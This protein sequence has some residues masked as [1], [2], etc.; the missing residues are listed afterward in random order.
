MMKKIETFIDKVKN[1][2]NI[3]ISGHKNPDGDAMGCALALMKV[4]E[5]N[6]NKKATVIYDGNIPKDLDNIPL[7]KEVVCYKNIPED[8][9]FDLY[10]L[11]DY[12]T[13]NNLGGAERFVN[14]ADYIIEFDH[15]F[16]DDVIGDLCFDDI[17]KAATSQ[18]I[19]NV[20]KKADFKLDQDVINLLTIAII[21]D[22]GNFKFIR[23]SDVFKDAAHLVEDGADMAKLV[24][25]LQN[26]SKKTVLV[27]SAAVSNAE[28]L[29]KGRMAVAVINNQDYKKLDGRGELILSLLGQVHGVE[30]VLLFK[31]HKENQIGV[32][33]R[34]KTVP[35]NKLA[36]S[37]GGGGHLFA[38]GAVIQGSLDEVKE[39][40]IKSFQGM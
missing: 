15:H 37:F 31:E 8:S 32:S 38:S 23:H 20:I 10:I 17:E 3:A 33:L 21:T 28:F 14:K 40:V 25:L 19:Y 29:M 6:F 16:N 30:F 18:I 36:E 26:R 12:G 13:K 1:A 2:K 7:R 39:K 22:T 24:D 11:V 4:I 27:E 5:L 34:S 9:V 35:V